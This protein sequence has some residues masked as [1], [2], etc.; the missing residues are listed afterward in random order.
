MF[1]SLHKITFLALSLACLAISPALSQDR[2]ALV[3]GNSA[4]TGGAPLKNPVNDAKLI[5]KALEE[6][7]FQVTLLTDAEQK[8]MHR[9]M[10][11][12]G[13][14]LRDK[15]GAIGLLYYA[16][17]GLQVNGTNYMVPVSADI[18]DEAEVPVE[19]LDVNN[20][21]GT[22]QSSG[23]K[24]NIVILDACRN[25]PYARSF[26]SATR[27]LA[28]VQASSGLLIAY[29]TSPGD[30]AFDG[31]GINSP[32]S[33]ALDRH[34]REPGL[35]VETMFKRVLAE[36]E[37]ATERKQTP[38]M[39]TSFRGD[40]AFIDKG[41]Q[42]ASVDRSLSGDTA[43]TGE[44]TAQNSA[45]LEKLFWE[46]IVNSTNKAS[47]EAYM[48]AFP[49]GLF[50]PLAKIKVAELSRS[51]MVVASRSASASMPSAAASERMVPAAPPTAA[52]PRPST[53]R[54]GL[55][56][57]IVVT[58]A[59]PADRS[60]SG[61]NTLAYRALFPDSSQRE[62]TDADVKPLDCQKLWRARNEIYYRNGYCFKTEKGI[63]FFDNSN[64]TQANVSLKPLES[65][66]IRT[67]R[68]WEIRSRCVVANLRD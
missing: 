64:C 49:N 60:A 33:L 4:Y 10:I 15:P 65:R 14:K 57:G 42:T 21:I 9:G 12:F 52:A 18:K 59:A 55:G 32:Y 23:S 17:H 43:S 58:A 41:Q 3:I 7:G 44:S 28:P 6:T 35:P 36:V 54:G 5:A 51:E 38:W 8:Q 25:N 61:E 26:R 66:N 13:R 47:F 24:L 29:S 19:G 48:Q 63:R 53:G 34:I 62:L 1:R 67:I 40:F 2:F 22:M 30:V 31:S 68:T 45:A 50:V 20:F 56:S 46:S 11:D 37:D 27:G 16:G 39:T